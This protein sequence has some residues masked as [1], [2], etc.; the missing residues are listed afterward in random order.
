MLKTFSEENRLSVNE[1][2][3]TLIVE[4]CKGWLVLALLANIRLG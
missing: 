3:P 4:Y 2:E 1:Q